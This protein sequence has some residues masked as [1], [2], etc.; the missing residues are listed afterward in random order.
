LPSQVS[1]VQANIKTLNAF[2]CVLNKVTEAL[3]SPPK[4]SS[5]SEGELIKNKGK[6]AMSHKETKKEESKTDFEPVVKL[7]EQIKEQKR[8]KESVKADMAK[9]EMELGREELVDLLGIDVVTGFYKAKLQYDKYCNNMD[10]T[11]EVIPNFKANDLHLAK[12]REVVQ[13]CPNRTGCGW[14]TIYEQIQIRI[15]NLHKTE[16]DLRINFNKSLKEQDPLDK[17]NDLLSKKRK[18]VDDIP[19]YFKSTKK[20]K[21]SVQH[22]DYPARTVLNKPCLGMIM[23]N[24][25]QRQDLITTKDFKDLKNEMMHHT[26]NLF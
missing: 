9:Q 24:S 6:Q 18:H 17:L 26:R 11:D 3:D 16:Q 13:A 25:Y 10:G 14:T 19:N 8:I 7:T 2:P 1:S 21:S 15:E 12:W 20:F 4:T 23:F 22:E 5:Q